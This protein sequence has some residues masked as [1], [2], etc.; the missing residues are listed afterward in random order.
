[1]RCA[2]LVLVLLVTPLLAAPAPFTRQ[3]GKQPQGPLPESCTMRWGGGVYQ[4]RFFPGGAYQARIGSTTYVGYWRLD[5]L[6]L[7]LCESSNPESPW[8]FSHYII[9]LSPCRRKGTVSFDPPS[10]WTVE[11]SLEPAR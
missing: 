4:T 8:S 7:Y 1:M 2:L 9:E 6:T 3:R 5:G 11:F 10:G